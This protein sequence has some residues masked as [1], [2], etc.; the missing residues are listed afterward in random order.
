MKYRMKRHAVVQPLDTSY[1]IIPLTRGKSTMVDAA[2]FLW[3]DQWNWHVTDPEEGKYLPYAARTDS[4][5]KNIKM[6]QEILGCK[7][8]E[9]GHHRNH[10]TLD[11]RRQ[12]LRKC[13]QEQ[14]K[15]G[16][17]LQRNNTSGFIG[18]YWRKDLKMWVAMIGHEGKVLY[19]G[20]FSTAEEAAHARD[21]AAK[22]YH[23]EFAVLN[24]PVN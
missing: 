17:K 8:G 20:Q 19:L 3:L 24:F 21:E 23:G 22:K 15:K 14:N 12:N 1:K 6:H 10:N 9:E 5:G 18:V 13:T 2:D 7:P 4:N 11:N 16:K